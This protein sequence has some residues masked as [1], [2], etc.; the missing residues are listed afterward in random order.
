MTPRICGTCGL[1]LCLCLL[2]AEI[3]ELVHPHSIVA[4]GPHAHDEVVRFVTLGG[5]NRA[6]GGS[7]G[8]VVVTPAPASVQASGSAPI[9]AIRDSPAQPAT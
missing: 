2:T 8:S 3:A 9:V 1:A 5:E 7:S 4:T 6:V